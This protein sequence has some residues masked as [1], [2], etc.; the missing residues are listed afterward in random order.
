[1]VIWNAMRN[2]FVMSAKKAH[3]LT[4]VS[5]NIAPVL[6]KEIDAQIISACE[7]GNYSLDI[8]FDPKKHSLLHTYSLLK[9][10]ETTGYKL[11]RLENN[12]GVK[13]SWE[14]PMT[15]LITYD[16]LG[17]ERTRIIFGPATI[18]L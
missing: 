2:T 9:Y 16:W 18:W 5:Q 17:R 8:K 12:S 10:L 15:K 11:D 4:K 13:I 7:Q 6:E 14:K 3:Q 1:M